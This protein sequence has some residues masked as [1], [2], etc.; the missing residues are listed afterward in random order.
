VTTADTTELAP[1]LSPEKQQQLVLDHGH[2]VRAAVRRSFT[3][4]RGLVAAEDMEQAARMGLVEAART[5]APDQGVPFAAY[6]WPFACRRI[7]DAAKV[8]ARHVQKTRDAL[9]AHMV[10][11]ASEQGLF[12]RD[13]SS[14]RTELR[15]HASAAATAAWIGILARMGELGLSP[16]ETLILSHACSVMRQGLQKLEPRERALLE[17]HDIG[18]GELKDVARELGIPYSTARRLRQNALEQL[19]QA[20]EDDPGDDDRAGAG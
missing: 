3:R 5:F 20:L 2:V 16:E 10:H 14:F 17:G 9:H 12:E 6:A 13:D 7:A 19:R 4:L 18:G 11:V 8:Q 15:R 1:R